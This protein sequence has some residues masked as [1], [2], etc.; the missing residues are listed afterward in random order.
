[1]VD[2]KEVMQVSGPLTAV[3][4][5]DRVVSYFSETSFIV[6]LVGTGDALTVTMAILGVSAVVYLTT[7][8]GVVDWEEIA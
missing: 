5:L 3:P 1:M 6:D 2:N 8:L 7:A 4:A